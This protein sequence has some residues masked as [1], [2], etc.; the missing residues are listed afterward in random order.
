MIGRQNFQALLVFHFWYIK[1]DQKGKR[2]GNSAFSSLWR[3]I[4]K[5]RDICH[6]VSG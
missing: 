2:V 6:K 5:E 4:S 1:D 3:F